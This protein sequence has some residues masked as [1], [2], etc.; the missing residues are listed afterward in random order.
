MGVRDEGAGKGMGYSYPKLDLPL[1]GYL[2][3]RHKKAKIREFYLE[4]VR[5]NMEDISQSSLF[6]NNK[7]GEVLS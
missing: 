7:T 2:A 1:G 3:K 5:E 6:P 4:Q